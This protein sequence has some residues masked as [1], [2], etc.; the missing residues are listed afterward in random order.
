MLFVTHSHNTCTGAS[1]NQDPT[2]ILSSKDKYIQILLTGKALEG[3]KGK[4]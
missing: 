2:H 3:Q 4:L 1:Q